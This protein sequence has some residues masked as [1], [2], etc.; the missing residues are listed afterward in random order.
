MINIK[1]TNNFNKF[2]NNKNK[3]AFFLFLFIFLFPLFSNASS[4]TTTL[5]GT[6]N[7]NDSITI[8]AT[9][10]SSGGGGGGGGGGSGGGSYNPSTSVTFSG[11]AYPL[12]RVILLQD[13]QEILNTVAGPD[14]HF[15]ITVS[16]L[17]TGVYTF[18]ILGEDSNGQRSTLFTI[19]ISTTSNVATDV[20]GIFI[21][22]TI[23]IDKEQV[24]QGDTITVF[25]KTVPN[26]TV[27]IQTHS[28]NL[29][30]DT[31]TSDNSGGYIYNLNT[32]PLE[33]GN[34]ITKSKSSLTNVNTNPTSS[35][36]KLL[37]FKVGSENI[38]K[39]DACGNIADFNNDCHVNLIDFSIMAYW[40]HRTGVPKEID[41]NGDSFINLVDFSILAYHWNG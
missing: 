23:E 3:K 34:H 10:G 4:C 11:F 18:S 30:Q 38:M 24:K 25:G 8:S 36:S 15:S 40:Y 41:L 2:I 32:T 14:A 6:C 22:P 27:I 20:S 37:S 5:G 19:P 21:A 39:K 33:Y 1:L 7:L 9:V 16:N 31:V 17:N 26:A 12:S 13:G 29:I 28:D 35:F